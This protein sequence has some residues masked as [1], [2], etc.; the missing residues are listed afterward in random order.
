MG[1]L[2]GVAWEKEF[3]TDNILTRTKNKTMNPRDKAISLYEFYKDDSSLVNNEELAHQN[4]I[5]LAMRCVDETLIS[6]IKLETN[7]VKILKMHSTR[8][9]LTTP[10]SEEIGFW[11]EVKLELLNYKIISTFEK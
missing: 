9:I 4:A 5:K 11:H 6:L 7:V 2:D 8:I 3:G 10:A 1:V